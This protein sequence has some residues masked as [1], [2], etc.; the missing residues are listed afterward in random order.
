[1]P[2]ECGTTSSMLK[3]ITPRFTLTQ[4][5]TYPIAL[6]ECDTVR[7][8]YV[9]N[10]THKQPTEQAGSKHKLYRL[11]IDYNVKLRLSIGTTISDIH[12]VSPCKANDN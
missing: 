2:S 1:M 12:H 3:G 5:N 6:N 4:V 10:I 9:Y 11:D 7:H 8:M